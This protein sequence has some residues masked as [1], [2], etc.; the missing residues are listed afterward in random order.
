M[1]KIYLFMM[2]SVDSYFEG[3]NHDISWHNVDAEFNELAIENFKRTDT[4][5]FGRRTYELME[6]YW[7]TS[8][9]LRDDPI[10]AKSMNNIPKIVVSRTLDTVTETENWKN[11]RLIKEDVIAEVKKLKEEKGKNIVIFGSNDLCVSL[12]KENLIDEFQII[13][14]PVVVGRGAPL[15]AGLDKKLNL[16]LLNTRTFK[17]GNVLLSYKPS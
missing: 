13:V 17:N 7:P 10:I 6:S 12:M 8:E 9:A 2:V 16:K 4:L 15:F 11:V 5:L 3:E 1:K 14:N